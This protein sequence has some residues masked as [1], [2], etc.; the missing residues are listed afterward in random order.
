MQ[1]DNVYS[2]PESPVGDTLEAGSGWG[3]VTPAMVEHLARTKP[4][5]RLMAIVGFIGTAFLLI[6][7]IGLMVAGS[8][9]PALGGRGA[10]LGGLYLVLALVYVYPSV[11]L[12]RYASAV[13][14]LVDSR[15]L[16][17]MESALALQRSFWRLLG[18][19]TIAM[20]VVYVVAIVALVAVGVATTVGR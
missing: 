7:A 16:G 6:G 9:S 14:R 13:G 5:V 11:L 20:L 1:G 18:I 8:A 12:F 3:S 2:P 4:W 10:L 17:H 15:N 19:L